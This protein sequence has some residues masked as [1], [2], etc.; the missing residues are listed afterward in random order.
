MKYILR[1][2]VGQIGSENEG[3]VISTLAKIPF[4][5]KE[6]NLRQQQAGPDTEPTELHSC[7]LLDINVP[8]SGT[9]GHHKES[10]SFKIL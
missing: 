7:L 10:I 2:T 5:T 9:Q 8:M 6:A 3:A 1:L 4:F